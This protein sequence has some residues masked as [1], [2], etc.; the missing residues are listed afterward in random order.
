[1][2]GRI[3]LDAINSYCVISWNLWTFFSTTQITNRYR[4]LFIDFFRMIFAYYEWFETDAEK[5]SRFCVTTIV[6]I[7]CVSSGEDGRAR[8][9]WTIWFD[10]TIFSWCAGEY[11]WDVEIYHLLLHKSLYKFFDEDED[12]STFFICFTDRSSLSKFFF[13]LVYKHRK[14]LEVASFK[15]YGTY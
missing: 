1:M 15:S 12:N 5:V 7:W 2:E 11:G 10:K 9:T 6:A 4:S 8:K 13:F 3:T 14:F